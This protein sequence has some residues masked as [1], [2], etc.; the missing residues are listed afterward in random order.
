MEFLYTGSNVQHLAQTAAKR[1]IFHADDDADD[2]ESFRNL[3]LSVAPGSEIRSF[4]NG[5]ELVQQLSLLQPGELP[6]VIF[7]D[8]R[9]PIWDGIRTLNALS[10]NAKF[11]DIPVFM[12][13]TVDSKAEMDLCLKS[14]AKTYLTK[15]TTNAEHAQLANTLVHLLEGLEH[16]A[17]IT[18]TA[19]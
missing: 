2:R 15:A 9:M 11:C 8:L 19:S 10:S 4:S 6:E 13:S 16:R 12:M 17:V 7:L 3:V 18:G 14:G 1:Y 5:L